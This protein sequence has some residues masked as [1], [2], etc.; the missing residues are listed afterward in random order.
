MHSP[1][2]HLDGRA[3]PRF[4]SPAFDVIVV[5]PTT[6]VAPSPRDTS[7]LHVRCVTVISIEKELDLLERRFRITLRAPSPTSCR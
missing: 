1:S 2:R 6:V 3:C 5:D 4:S 7:R